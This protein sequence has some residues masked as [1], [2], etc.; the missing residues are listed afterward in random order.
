MRSPA[1]RHDDL[2]SPGRFPA[3][4]LQ[5][6]VDLQAFRFCHRD[7]QDHFGRRVR[8]Q[9][10]AGTDAASRLII[11][12]TSIRGSV[13]AQFAQAELLEEIRRHAADRVIRSYAA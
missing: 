8:S 2:G 6:S 3:A 9:V 7:L 12:R 13:L 11:H 4:D 10:E 1:V 5:V